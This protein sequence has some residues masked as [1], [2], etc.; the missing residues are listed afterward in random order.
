MSRFDGIGN[1]LSWD[2]MTYLPPA[3]AEERAEQMALIAKLGHERLIS[4]ELG[5]VLDELRPLEPS[6]TP[7]SF[8]ACLI[9]QTRRDHERARR[10]PADFL[11]KYSNH[12]A[13]AHYIW[14]RARAM[15][16]FKMAIPALQKSV[17]LSREYASFFP[18]HAHPA[19][20]L[21][22]ANDP[23][24]TVAFLKP[25]FAEL[26][27]QLLQLTAEIFAQPQV[28]DG[29]LKLRYPKADQL[30]FG[31]WLAEKMGFDFER[32]RV[33]ESVHPFMAKLGPRDVRIT[34]RFNERDFMEGLSNTVHEGGHAMYEQNIAPELQG[35]MLGRGPSES[36]HESQSRL[37]E[38]LVLRDINVWRFAYPTLQAFFP[39]QLRGVPLDNFYRA[40]NKVAPTCIRTEADEVTYN[41][42]AIMR[43]GFELA[44]LE[45]SLAV[46]DLPDAW[47]EG[48]QKDLGITP[49]DDRQGVLQDPHWFDS[50]LFTFSAYVLGNI[51]NAQFY[52]KALSEQPQIPAEFAKGDFHSLR[53]WLTDQIYRHG[54]KYTALE[55]IQKATGRPPDTAAIMRYLRGKYGEIYRL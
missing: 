47:R 10:L 35:T 23:N 43:F 2:G 51:L 31:N 54:A 52:E 14:S 50:S 36:L 37:W 46:Q 13:K 33:D 55:I 12:F 39:G 25:L 15:N 49:P 45:G 19:D 48:M 28:E 6:L 21:L 18:G 24:V 8:E 34:T 1:L 27:Q 53:H 26:R 42:H 16:S 32:G 30:R 41:L 29:F 17:D 3:A 44:L 22:H 5:Q 38:Y 4:D 7:D 9:R 11:E 40:I 20:P